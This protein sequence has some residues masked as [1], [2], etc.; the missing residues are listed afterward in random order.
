MYHDCLLLF[1]KFF[2]KLIVGHGG[3]IGCLIG[4]TDGIL[5]GTDGTIFFSTRSAMD[6]FNVGSLEAFN[7]AI[8]CF[9]SPIS[10]FHMYFSV[11]N[12]NLCLVAPRSSLSGTLTTL[13]FRSLIPD[14]LHAL[15]V[16]L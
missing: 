3:I 7:V 13:F 6:T 16:Y 2:I 15:A 10:S 5:S 11:I 4:I 12:N 8:M 14:D 9:A 1:G